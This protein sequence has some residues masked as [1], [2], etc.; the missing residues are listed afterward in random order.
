[1]VLSPATGVVAGQVRCVWTL[2]VS[3]WEPL[4]K[5]WGPFGLI[6][7]GLILFIWKKL[8]PDQEKQRAEYQTALNSALD[9]ARRERDYARQQREKEV[10]KF[11]QSLDTISRRFESITSDIAEKR[12]RQR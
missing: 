6:V 4:I 10:D 11:I 1:M 12:A 5:L 7:V 8:L 2:S 3:E 9:D